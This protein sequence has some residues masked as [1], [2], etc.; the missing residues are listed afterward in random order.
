MKNVPKNG[1]L[2]ITPIIVK[3]KPSKGKAVDDLVKEQMDTCMAV[4]IL[5]TKDDKVKTEKEE[6]YQPR[7]NVIHE[8]GLA[9]EKVKDKII[10]L[11]QEG[12]IFPSNI[13]PK[14]WENF[15]Q[16]NMENAFSKVAKEL[17]AFR[18]IQLG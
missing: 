3:N 13:S 14:V 11:K 2:G 12:C 6:Y 4:I 1:G 8:I 17:R 5:A 10:Y 7:P 9:Q 16:G 18:I 15:T